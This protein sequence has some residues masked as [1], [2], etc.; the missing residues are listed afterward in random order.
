[1][2]EADVSVEPAGAAR[3][4][5]SGKASAAGRQP[6]LV[7]PRDFPSSYEA[8]PAALSRRGSFAFSCSTLA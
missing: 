6:R 5:P 7:R 1:M 4:P 3:L 2:H 8:E